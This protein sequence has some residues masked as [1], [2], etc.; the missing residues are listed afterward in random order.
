[1][2][3]V[4]LLAFSGGL[5]AGS[6]NQ[7]LLNRAADLACDMG[8]VVTRINL[9]DFPLPLFS[10]QIEESTFPAAA[11]ELKSLLVDHSGFLIASPEYNGSVTGVLKNA[12]DWVSR[13]TD[14]EAALA[15][16]A[17][18]NKIAG[19]MSTSVSAFGGMRSLQHLRQ[20][21]GTVHTLVATQQVVVPFADKAFD[22][23]KLVDA[24][25]QQLL[26]VLV[27]QVIHLARATAQ[28]PLR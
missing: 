15:C 5:R 11:R 13:P 17:F 6:F 24:M 21:L 20:I 18:R 4:K 14:G 23:E 22:G 16:S 27:G 9:S 2:T 12:I 28:V 8:A 10:P 3:P 7:K 25:P 19:I 1:M 26:P